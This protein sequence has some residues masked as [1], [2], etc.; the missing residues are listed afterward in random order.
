M[1]KSINIR[2]PRDNDISAE[3]LK[4]EQQ[5]IYNNNL[6]IMKNG[7][8]GNVKN[9]HKDNR[10]SLNDIERTMKMSFAGGTTCLQQGR[11]E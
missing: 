5:L 11:A 6:T 4:G 9:I 10:T 7:S 3:I 1:R 8:N 2:S